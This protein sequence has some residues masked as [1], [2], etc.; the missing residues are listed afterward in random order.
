MVSKESLLRRGLCDEIKRAVLKE[1]EQRYLNE[2][3]DDEERQ[4]VRDR[5]L[6]LR[7]EL[8]F[9]REPAV[10]SD[11]R[12]GVSSKGPPVIS[13]AHSHGLIA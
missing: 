12:A 1:A 10:E 2:L 4:V 11:D 13:L 6:K 7:R 9:A 5:V 3:L 8:G